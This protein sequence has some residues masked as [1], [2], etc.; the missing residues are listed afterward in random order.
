M[1]PLITLVFWE[2]LAGSPCRVWRGADSLLWGLFVAVAPLSPA[3]RA[4]MGTS[5]TIFWVIG[6]LQGGDH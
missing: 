3:S 2:G 1:P 4:C 5:L 6:M